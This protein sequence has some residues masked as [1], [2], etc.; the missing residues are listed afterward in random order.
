MTDSEGAKHTEEHAARRRSRHGFWSGVIAGA[1]FGALLTGAVAVGAKALA[2]GHPGGGRW[3][4]FRHEDPERAREHLELAT[5][6]ILSRVEAT[7]DQKGQAKRVVSETFD[8]LLQEHRSNHEALAEEMTKASLDPEAIERLRQS[9]VELIDRA[10]KELTTSLT[11]IAGVLTPEQ[12][13]E[14]A[15]LIRRFHH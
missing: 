14:L 3:G 9:Q 2:A 4:H 1:L 8:A 12:R 5:D 10:S 7:D 6:W 13:A 15:E 11:E